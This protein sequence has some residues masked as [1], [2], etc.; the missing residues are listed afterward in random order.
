MK[1]FSLFKIYLGLVIGLFFLI[2][3]PL[4]G[5]E[6]HYWDWSRHLDLA[7]YSKGP[8]TALLIKLSTVL[9]GNREWAVRLPT[10]CAVL[11]SIFLFYKILFN[12]FGKEISQL[13][14][15]VCFSSV[16]FVY[17][18]FFMTTDGTALLCWLLSLYLYE[19]WEKEGKLRYVF[20]NATA[21]GL[22]IWSKYTCAVLIPVYL[23][24][25][26]K[27]KDA[28]WKR[29]G[30][31]LLTL[32]LFFI[33]ILIWNS[34]H[35]WVNLLHNQTHVVGGVKKGIRLSYLFDFLGAQVG[36]YGL[37]FP[38]SLF[39]LF[40]LD[41]KKNILK[42]P[43]LIGA[44]GLFLICFL[45]S[46]TKRIYPNW[47]IPA[48]S[49][50]LIGLAPVFF[51]FMDKHKKFFKISCYI[52]LAVVLVSLLLLQDYFSFIPGK[53]LPTKKVFG[54]K[55]LV[56]EIGK[57]KQVD[58]EVL[59]ESYTIASLY[60]FYSPG[61]Q[62]AISIPLGDRRMNQLDIWN[63]ERGLERYK[64]KNFIVV[65]PEYFQEADLM[66][67]FQE[68]QGVSEFSYDF[69]AS[70]LHQVKIFRGTSFKG[71]TYPGFKKF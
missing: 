13:L 65:T 35:A 44:G 38:L 62:D 71:Y 14:T 26:L 2:D 55:E 59:M 54:Y 67:L 52:N 37:F 56:N 49:Y 1:W 15:A 28:R 57:Y 20:Y 50:L 68:V 41:N 30:M 23:F 34:E 69:H 53:F 64:G 48:Y 19:A 61:H 11:L 24:F 58:E 5:D 3:L 33:P 47:T 36:L 40:K 39:L 70:P 10:L 25:F 12:R 21:L 4:S 60:K 29:V 43:A 31:F 16:G 42:S 9:F 7:Y 8:L 66:G 32:A 51:E 22:G 45:V 27:E 18:M 63:Q 17:P 6:A 46:F